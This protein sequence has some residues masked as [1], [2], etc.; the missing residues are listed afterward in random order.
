MTSEMPCMTSARHIT[1][2][3][4]MTRVELYE[5]GLFIAKFHRTMGSFAF[6]NS[7]I[8]QRVRQRVIF[9]V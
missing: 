9:S 7:T 5:T 2:T 1:L 3:L 6:S 4:T 8:K